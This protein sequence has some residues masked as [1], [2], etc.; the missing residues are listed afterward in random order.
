MVADRF[1]PIEFRSTVRHG[2]LLVRDAATGE[3][4]EGTTPVEFRTDP[5][6]GRSLRLVPFDLSRVIR[7][8]LDAL[9]QRSR[10]LFCPFCPPNVT[11]ITPVFP[12]DLVPEGTL[13]IGEAYGFPNL[14]P[15]DVHGAVIVVSPE[16]HCIRLDAFDEGLITDALLTAHTHLQRV[17]EADP[18]ARYHFIA[19]NYLPA[20]GG[21]LVHPHLQSNAG[22]YP[23]NIQREVIEAS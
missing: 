11:R 14:G 4:A 6:T 18:A 12:P 20:A 21:S 9:E 3:L 16:R 1:T 15:Y 8:D 13:N 17:A 10:E 23:T 19:W 22:F 2:R 7:P 5:L